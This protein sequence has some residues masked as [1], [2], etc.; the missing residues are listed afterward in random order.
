MS[1][2]QIILTLDYEIFGN[3]SGDPK[4]CMIEPT[5]KLLTLASAYKV[6]ITIMLEICEYWAFQKEE[7]SGTLPIGY[8]PARWIEE[9]LIAA[10][11]AGHDI[12]LHIHP[13]WLNYTYYPES[14]CWKVDLSKW[15]ASALSYQELLPLLRQGKKALEEL[16]QPH[17]ADYECYVF[18]AGAFSLQPETQVLKALR[19]AGFAIDTTAATGCC[20]KSGTTFYDFKALPRKPYWVVKE[21]LAEEA[22]QGILE[23]PIYTRKYSTLERIAYSLLRKLAR[24]NTAPPGCRG[25]FA[26][27]TG[28]HILERLAPAYLK[29]D[30]CLMS[31]WEILM[32][33]KQAEK[34]YHNYEPLPIVAIG[35][36]KAFNSPKNFENFLKKALNKGFEFITFK[37]LKNQELRFYEGN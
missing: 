15:R 1:K 31:S 13:Q 9:Q 12:Q 37:P 8:T 5:R 4:S 30:F 26:G 24:L 33:L 32:L 27:E 11:A 2:P 20:F 21:N 6:P 14:R 7:R 28:R 29:L 22:P 3:G 18:R 36:S 25:S 17:R 16:L 19:D 10:L 34:L 35:H 23:I